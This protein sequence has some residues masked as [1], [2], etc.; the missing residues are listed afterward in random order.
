MVRVML[1][2]L[3]HLPKLAKCTA[4]SATTHRGQLTVR[5]AVPH[6]CV[7][8]V[9][10]H[11]AIKTKIGPCMPRTQQ[12]HTGCRVSS[13]TELAACC[14]LDNDPDCLSERGCNVLDQVARMTDKRCF[15][16]SCVSAVLERL[17]ETSYASLV[18]NYEW[19]QKNMNIAYIQL[20]LSGNLTTIMAPV[21]QND[22]FPDLVDLVVREHEQFT[23]A[24]LVNSLV[25]LLYL[26]T[27]QDHPV[28]TVLLMECRKRLPSFDFPSLS[29]MSTVVKTLPGI[30]PLSSRLL[31]QRQRS[32]LMS[33]DYEWTAADLVA[34]CQLMMN[35]TLYSSPD[36]V[37]R[38][39]RS[40]E[41]VLA[42]LDIEAEPDNLGTYVRTAQKLFTYHRADKMN[43]RNVLASITTACHSVAGRLNAHHIAE[44]CHAL[45]KARCFDSA[46]AV[47]MEK[48]AYELLLSKDCKLRD[49]SNLFYALT[50]RTPFRV[51]A[52]FEDALLRALNRTDLDVI[53]LSNLA[54][55]LGSIGQVNR[56]LLSAI[57]QLVANKADHI[58]TYMSRYQ[59]IVRFLIRKRFRNKEHEFMLKE[60]L[61]DYV[62]KREGI[63]TYSMPSIATFILPTSYD[64]LPEPF[65]RKLLQSIP[66]WSAGDLYRLAVGLNAMRQP[67]TGRLRR[68]VS[69]IQVGKNN[70]TGP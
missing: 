42:T 38:S 19:L 35:L 15:Q 50:R 34:H 10:R 37:L 55:S 11:C 36:L 4:V 49:I 61:L 31:V 56:E 12:L 8:T 22:R 33:D 44:I 46:I 58:V 70:Q 51:K 47:T 24:E 21:Q 40:L 29:A 2:K 60:K 28:V 63:Y 20:L 1:G 39:A 59:K 54:D 65:Y 5:A 69:T 68:Q 45:K 13:Q 30:D 52:A 48:R 41:K 53:I 25:A 27:P 66:R 67:M 26:A 6:G 32:L 18:D 7:S 64:S 14:H 57:H 62:N 16:P 23:N 43:A 3:H 9:Y 17:L